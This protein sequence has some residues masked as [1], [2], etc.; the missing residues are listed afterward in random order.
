MS[1]F[2]RSRG[3]KEDEERAQPVVVERLKRPAE[4]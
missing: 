2:L 4:N 1:E 3:A